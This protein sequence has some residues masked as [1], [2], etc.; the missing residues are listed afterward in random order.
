M[1]PF[2]ASRTSQV[3]RNTNHVVHRHEYK[4]RDGNGSNQ[5]QHQFVAEKYLSLLY[6]A[7]RSRP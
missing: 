4:N 3:A 6:A 5:E 2:S 7:V 1:N